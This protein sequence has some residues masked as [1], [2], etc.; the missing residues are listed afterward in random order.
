MLL[1]LLLLLFED[2][3]DDDWSIGSD[4]LP[5]L[6]AAQ[7]AEEAREARVSTALIKGFVP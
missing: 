3:E 2:L 7:K 4:G 6:A 1:L 5:L